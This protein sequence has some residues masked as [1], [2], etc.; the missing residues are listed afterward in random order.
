MADR[1]I[2]TPRIWGCVL[3]EGNG[4]IS[5]DAV[6]LAKTAIAYPAGTVLGLIT[7]TKQYVFLAPAAND[8]RQTA[9]AV[10]PAAVDAT[11]AAMPALVIARLAEV[12]GSA[13]AWPSG[14]TAPQKAAATADL[15]AATIIVR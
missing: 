10:L 1:I 7:A 13:L 4:K 15:A 2:E 12:S 8:G 5:R 3:S 11:A 14:I 6:T 9:A